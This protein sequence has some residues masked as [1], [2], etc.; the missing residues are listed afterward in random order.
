M[1]TKKAPIRKYDL[2]W[3]V[4][5]ELEIEHAII[6]KGGSFIY[7]GSNK[8]MKG[9][10]VG[11]G[12]LFHHQEFCR[13]AWPEDDEHRWS[14]LV[15]QTCIQND[16]VGIMGPGD[17]GKTYPVAKYI[18][19][20]YFC[21][22][23]STLTVVCTTEERGADQR[24]FGA[25]K[26]LFGRAKSRF[27]WLPGTLID[28]ENA[29]TTDDLKKDK[30][31]S[32]K[33][34][35]VWVPC[36]MRS[37]NYNNIKVFV[38]F[39]QKRMRMVA[40][41]A[42]FLGSAFLDALANYFGKE[43]VKAFILGNPVDTMDCLG[44]ACEPITGWDTHQ[45]PTK[46]V[47]WPTKWKNGICLNLVGTDSP[48]FDHPEEEGDRYPYMTGWK[49]M[50]FIEH[51]YG[52]DSLNWYS[53]M[54]GVMRG[55]INSKRVIT[56]QI[57]EHGKAFDD[58]IWESL[59]LTQIYFL[60]AAYGGVGG[61]RCVG[62]R[63]SF[64]K[65]ADGIHRIKI[66]D[67]HLV[68]VSVKILEITP[69]DQI[70]AFVYGKCEEFG[71]AG[72]NVFYD[73]T[74]R[75]TLGTA[76]AKKFGFTPPEGI[77]FGGRPSG[78]P[79]RHDLYM[80][81]KSTGQ[82]RHIRC[83]EY[84]SKFVSEL[85]YSVRYVIECDQMRGLPQDVAREGC[86]REFRQVAGN[87]IEV[88]PKEET[89]LRLGRSPDLFDAVVTGIEGARRRGFQIRMFAQLDPNVAKRRTVFDELRDLADKQRKAMDSKRLINV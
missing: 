68:P 85:W 52:R 22:S 59:E 61:D 57:C 11:K 27:P 10:K 64:G 33:K 30:I 28:S 31:R 82:K 41:E 62:G 29:I 35:I 39:K 14:K 17:S 75:G 84:Y 2:D 76:F 37:N 83:D 1:S 45:E 12:L 42:Q 53:Q 73:D 65:C 56:M 88:E 79:V 16:V 48:N 78:R 26:E 69:E 7:E 43:D 89:K 46:T 38:G 67:V 15:H 66:H 19:T 18:L 49:K 8:E 40:D 9:K 50:R 54:M 60:D 87:K 70:A 71:I 3:D 51:S 86:M 47:T 36:A 24:I 58:L 25:I 81:D 74:G 55:G 21:N 5:D 6:S 34:G 72:P 23:S 44:Q 77:A 80:Q 32:M 20:D 4:R 13:M 63:L